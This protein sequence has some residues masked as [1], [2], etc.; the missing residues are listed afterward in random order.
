MTSIQCLYS[1][2]NG[3]I[4][5]CIY[6][7]SLATREYSWQPFTA[8]E[9]PSLTPFRKLSWF[10]HVHWALQLKGQRNHSSI[11]C[12]WERSWIL[13]FRVNYLKWAWT[14]SDNLYG[15]QPSYKWSR[16]SPVHPCLNRHWLNASA[17]FV[18][19]SL[20]MQ[21]SCCNSIIFKV[22]S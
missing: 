17:I 19:V 14:L 5:C 22:F 3:N 11:Y 18:N 20:V 2:T 6:R 13:M 1:W 9:I 15:W 12:K 10:Q 21:I 4:S 7:N 16:C 8:A